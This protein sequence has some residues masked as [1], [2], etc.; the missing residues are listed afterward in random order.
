M[1][2]WVANSFLFIMLIA[3]LLLSNLWFE[4]QVGVAAPVN[5]TSLLLLIWLVIGA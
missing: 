5:F 1:G 3:L 2:K 4:M